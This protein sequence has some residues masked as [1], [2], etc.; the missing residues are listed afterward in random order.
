MAETDRVMR[1]MRAFNKQ[2]NAAIVHFPGASTAPA[3]CLA[4]SLGISARQR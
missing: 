2:V 1:E 4:A 3:L